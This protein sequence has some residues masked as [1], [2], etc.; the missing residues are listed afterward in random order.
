MLRT[1]IS[2]YV[3]RPERSTAGLVSTT[4]HGPPTGYLPMSGRQIN[5]TEATEKTDD[6]HEN[7]QLL[8]TAV[9]TDDELC[10]DKLRL[11]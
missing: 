8:G 1:L 6:M 2:T 4:E 10:H 9:T 5:P 3:R 11:T 7:D